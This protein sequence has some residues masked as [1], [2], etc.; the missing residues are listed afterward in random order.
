MEKAEVIHV[1]TNAGHS[2]GASARKRLL[3][4]ES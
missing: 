2:N 3:K 4:H 1:I